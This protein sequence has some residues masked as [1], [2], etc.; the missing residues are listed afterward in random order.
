MITTRFKEVVWTG[1]ICA[2]ALSF[3][4][5]SQTVAAK[6]A[7][8]AGV[9]RKITATNQEI[10]RLRTEID[11]RGALAQIERWNQNVYGLQAPGAE[12][13]ATSSIRLVAL[14][15]P[16][17]QP[18]LPL[19]RGIVASHGA[20]NQVRYD[21]IEDRAAEPAPVRTAAAPRPEPVA[22]PA[23]R[24]ANYVQAKPSALASEAPSPVRE[25]SVRTPARPTGLGD[26]FLDGLVE[27]A[28]AR[29]RKGKP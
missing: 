15:Q 16:Q 28:P 24:Q 21:Q 22:Q 11:T 18:Q 20:L 4:M 2:A 3:Y 19:D 10:R 17:Q 23:L 27:D 5:I 25:I 29:V 12:Q 6:R 14:T 13:F 9:E 8:L 7:E 26:D 1:G